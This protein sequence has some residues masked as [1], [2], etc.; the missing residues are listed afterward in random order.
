MFSISGTWLQGF[1][2]HANG[3]VKYGSCFEKFQVLMRLPFILFG[4]M[5]LN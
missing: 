2:L 3:D 5:V 1:L 4:H